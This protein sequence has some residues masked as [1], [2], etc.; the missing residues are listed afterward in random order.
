MRR[1]SNS[2]PDWAFPDRV[3]DDQV[4]QTEDVS[5][6]AGAIFNPSTDGER[7][8]VALRCLADLVVEPLEWVF[9]GLIPRGAVTLLAG[10]SGVGKSRLAVGLMAA[11]LRGLP[12]PLEGAFADAN[13]IASGEVLGELA[14]ERGSLLAG[15][16]TAAAAADFLS[17]DEPCRS[18]GPAAERPAASAVVV[19]SSGQMLTDSIR[20]RL[21]EARADLARVYS[22]CGV[23][24][25]LPNEVDS[26]VGEPGDSDLGDSE[27]RGLQP[28]DSEPWACVVDGGVRPWSFQLQRDLP[29]LAAEL[30]RLKAEGVDVRMIVI[31]PVDSLL[32]THR[33]R[34][35]VDA[36]V[37][38]LAALAR[39][40]GV[41]IVAVS[42]SGTAETVR[43]FR[44]RGGFG[45]AALSTVARTVW[46]LVRDL[47]V[48]N[49]RM[50]I[51]V[52]TAASVVPRGF[53]YSLKDG[54]IEWDTEPVT[55][56]GDDYVLEAAVQAQ[57][58]LAREYR[59]ERDRAAAWLYERLSAGRV[60]S[61][62]VRE[63]A[64]ENEIS[65]RT[66]RRAFGSLGCKS[67][68]ERGKGRNAQYFWRLPGEG[69][70]YRAGAPRLVGQPVQAAQVGQPIETPA[71]QGFE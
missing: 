4:G 28:G 20:P 46:T 34:S 31:D 59:F 29:V 19:F 54:V 66:L 9:E 65:W 43:S 22:L 27:S 13:E 41:A 58:P 3:D 11:V 12:G 45:I 24:D 39:R 10:D 70:F 38:R 18:L 71:K 52:K 23:D 2:P 1:F 37:A 32:E 5:L 36:D 62:I 69:F 35:L 60:H 25:L 42:N 15:D 61:A 50:L 57:N 16:L 40:T 53:G 17:G 51:P 63:D 56:T 47:D 8:K 21:I 68:R 6:A 14:C 30:G 44:R 55:I 64:A 26:G 33:S 7:P 48:A 49:R 67:E